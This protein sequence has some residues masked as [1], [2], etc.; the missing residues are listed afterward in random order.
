LLSFIAQNYIDAISVETN[1]ARLKS[2]I[3]YCESL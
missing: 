3:I 2:D 1:N